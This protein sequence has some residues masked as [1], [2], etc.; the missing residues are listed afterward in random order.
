MSD[1]AK[2]FTGSIPQIYDRY[3]GPMF[4]EPFARD[5]AGR[6]AGF[7]GDILETAAGTGQVTRLLAQAA[8]GARIVATDLNEPML[9]RAA[10][11]VKAPNVQ[12]RQ[13]DAQALPFEDA[14]FD[15]VV[16]Q[17]GAMFFPD[18][19]KAYSETW[20]VLRPGGRFVFSV[21]DELAAND[22]TQIVEDAVARLFPD[23][24]PD[25]FARGPFGY[26]DRDLIRRSLLEA[27]FATAEIESVRLPTPS[28]SPREAALGLVTGTPLRALIEARD[29]AR[30]EEAVDVATQ[31]LAA[32]FG[33]GAFSATGQTVIIVAGG[34][35]VS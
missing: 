8:R 2:A 3:M 28:A 23:D 33:E 13:A 18:K 25:F 1:I 15:A 9:A 19:V 27:G 16:C 10:Q 17:F 11:A 12:W 7:E 14:A 20:R 35:G 24:P 32:Q 26:H 5:L 4:F 31:A 21:W 22:A 29:P 30:V 6:F 34:G